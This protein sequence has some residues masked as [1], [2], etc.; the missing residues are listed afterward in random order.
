MA[1]R[2]SMKDLEAAVA[3]M[4]LL[5]GK[6]PFTTGAFHLRGNISGWQVDQKLE[7]G[8]YRSVFDTDHAAVIRAQIYAWRDGYAAGRIASATTKDRVQPTN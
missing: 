3:G 8:G 4:N 7:S 1:H 5:V 6:A 2:T